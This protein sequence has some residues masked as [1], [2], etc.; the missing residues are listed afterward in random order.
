MT[1][2]KKQ[3]RS[4]QRDGTMNLDRRSFQKTL[5]GDLYHVLMSSSWVKLLGM[6]TGLFLMINL[7]FGTAYFLAGDQA[8]EGMEAAA[9]W[10]HWLEC[11]FFSVQTFATIGYGKLSPLSL[12]AHLLVTLEA[13][14]GLLSVAMMTGMIFSRFSRP[15]ARVLF[16]ENLLI[17]EIDSQPSLV[18]RMANVRLNQIVEA[19]VRVVLLQTETTA[20]GQSFREFYELVLER[21]NSPLFSMSWTVI[22]PIDSESPLYGK[23]REQIL[24]SDME[25]MVTLNGTDDTFL[26]SVYSR[27]AYTVEDILWNVHFADMISRTPEGRL[28][29]DISA[30]NTIRGT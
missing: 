15:T 26:Q 5:F 21:S 28:H 22:H 29:V 24:N 20:E 16:S 30:I 27:K 17:T 14:I 2:P 4:L 8:L 3:I 19:R 10:A 9:G 1:L 23:T 6:I 13:L 25:F 12:I 18:F 11:V 7:F